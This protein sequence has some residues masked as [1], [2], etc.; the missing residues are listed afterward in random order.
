MEPGVV[1]KLAAMG[2]MAGDP[3]LRRLL[4]QVLGLEERDIDLVADLQGIAAVHED[5]GLVRQHHGKAGRAGKTGKPSQAL[6]PGRHIFALMLIGPGHQEAGETPASQFLSQ[7]SKTLGAR[8]QASGRCLRCQPPP[9][10]IEL[11]PAA[12]VGRGGD[13]VDPVQGMLPL[14]GRKHPGEKAANLR[15]INADA[16]FLQHSSQGV[17]AEIS[18]FR[19]THRTVPSPFRPNGVDPG[20]I[21]SDMRKHAG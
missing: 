8:L 20:P 11:G 5:G 2:Q 15:Q 19:A 1:A 21:V 6:G 9:Q 17:I 13:E 18:L 10:G 3:A 4:G 14:R 7:C 12:A 16:G